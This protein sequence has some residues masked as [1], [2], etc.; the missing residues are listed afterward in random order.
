STSFGTAQR[1]R[2]PMFEGRI[3]LVT[4]AASGIGAATARL[5]AE[6]GAGALI[7]VDADGERLDALMQSIPTLELMTIARDV[8]DEQAWDRI[9]HD[10]KGPFGVID[11]AV[12]NAGVS[13]ASRIVDTDYETW[14]HVL[15]VN[16]DGAFLSLRTAMRLMRSGGSIVLVSSVS[17][18]K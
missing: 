14:R 12:I 3:A 17:G 11:L 6:S 5:L 18:T 10:A 15:G 4:G 16:L 13:S 2:E 9:E 8:R 7:L 1:T